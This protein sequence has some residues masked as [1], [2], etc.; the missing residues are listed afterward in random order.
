M[1]TLGVERGVSTVGQQMGFQREFESVLAAA[2]ANG[3]INDPEIAA[4]VADAWIGLQVLRCTAR[5]TLGTAFDN[6]GPGA[7]PGTEANVAKL[8]WA[9]WHQ[10]LG[11]LAVD[12]AGASATVTGP[13]YD[14][15]PAQQLF[16]ATR[17]DTIYGGSS[18]IQRNIVAE[19]RLGLPRG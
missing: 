5:A 1:G 12:V 18:E 3:S 2:R 4:R 14:L 15:S 16:L 13:D 8:L 9:P 19:R 11:E 17:A 10:R 7:A 6:A